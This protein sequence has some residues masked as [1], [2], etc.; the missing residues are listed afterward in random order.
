MLAPQR[1]ECLAESGHEHHHRRCGQYGSGH[2]HHHSFIHFRSGVMCVMCAVWGT[3]PYGWSGKRPF[4]A[5]LT[6]LYV[7]TKRT[8]ATASTA[9]YH[10]T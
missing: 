5:A 8:K 6:S 7:E 2:E 1:N 9:V 3:F 10:T 4:C